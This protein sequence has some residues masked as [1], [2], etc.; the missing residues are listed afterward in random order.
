MIDYKR[1]H[2]GKLI[3]ARMTEMGWDS[4][5]LAEKLE[6]P[7]SE[8]TKLLEEEDLPMLTVLRLSKLL[9]YDFF[10]LYSTHLLLY[11]S[12]DKLFGNHRFHEENT[13]QQRLPRFRKNV[14]TP[15]VISFILKELVSENRNPS[16]VSKKYNIP[17]TTLY[18]WYTKYI[19]EHPVDAAR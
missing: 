5:M 4:K 19:H 9:K 12:K 14:Y 8:I 10:R 7:E 17:K 16:E 15:E 18:R 11:C 1:L 6:F 13:P 3:S 2:I